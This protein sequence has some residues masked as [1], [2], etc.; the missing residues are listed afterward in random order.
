MRYLLS[1]A[2]V[3]ASAASVGCALSP[4]QIETDTSIAVNVGLQ[5]STI[6]DKSKTAEIQAD[7]VTVAQAINSA[8]LPQ[9]QP[10]ATSGALLNSAVQQAELHLAAKLAALKHGPEI[11][12]LVTLLQA[13]LSGMLGVTASPTALMSATARQNALG[14]F[15]GISQ[16]I[17]AFTG[18]ASLAPP[19]LPAMPVVPVQAAPVP[20]AVPA[21]P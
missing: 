19:P 7:A 2:L 12:G 20:V 16:G 5:A 18:N 4:Q 3:L 14:F 6:F 11:L 21:K 17:S 8:V 9:F 13:P 1:V 10:G 15:S